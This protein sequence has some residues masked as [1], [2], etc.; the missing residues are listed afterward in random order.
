MIDWTIGL[1]EQVVV[2]GTASGLGHECAR[3]LTD[4]GVRVFGVDVAEAGG[5]LTKADTFSE[6]RGSVT[7]PHTWGHVIAAVDASARLARPHRR[8]G[9]ARRRGSRR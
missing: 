5:E 3:L 8:C 2:T 4:A 9:R 1:P 7:E 6:V